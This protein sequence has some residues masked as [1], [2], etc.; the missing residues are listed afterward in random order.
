MEEK[1]RESERDVSINEYM[2]MIKMDKE[3][4]FLLDYNLL[5]FNLSKSKFSLTN[6]HSLLARE[7]YRAKSE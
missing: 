4:C 5:S 6:I 7:V 1:I 2:K 3:F